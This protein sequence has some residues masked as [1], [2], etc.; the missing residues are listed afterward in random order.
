MGDAS[1]DRPEVNARI[2]YWGVE[3]AGKESNLR[4]I[5]GKLRP[6]HRGRLEAVPT[7]LD[8]SVCSW[9]L[10]IELGEIAG[11]RTRIQVVAVP[12]GSE[13]APTRKQLLD[14]VDGVV[15]VVDAR[16]DRIDE[17]VAAFEE[18]RS[19][20]A[21]YGRS[22]ESVPLVV[23]YNHHDESDPYVL[24]ELH[25]KLDVKGAAAFEAKASEG[26][27]V[28][29]TLTTISKRVVRQLR[30]PEAARQ[31]AAPSAPVA[32]PVSLGA[33]LLRTPRDLE[34]P[35]ARGGSS[36]G[37]LQDLTAPADPR[38]TAIVLDPPPAR[39]DLEEAALSVD[40]D[41]LDERDDAVSRAQDLLDPSW[42]EVA[43]DFDEPLETAMPLGP[44]SLPGGWHVVSA[45]RPTIVGAATLQIP[46]RIADDLGRELGFRL[47][48]S[49]EPL[50]DE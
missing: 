38:S 42:S 8:P 4:S 21:A 20:L 47:T 40:V 37:P 33:K 11:V 12:G 14:R 36:A 22:L 6:D 23:Q 13:Q 25:R 30:E 48:V 9:R 31:P 19:A 32:P 49:L 27:G 18:L 10:P 24:E 43:G 29:P 39:L 41:M 44:A 16:R 26:T 46:L 3:G 45:G 1:A 50:L 34:S 35:T 5:H 7:A 2:V 28:L 15:L 17:N